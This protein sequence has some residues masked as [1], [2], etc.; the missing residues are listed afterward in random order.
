M[1]DP[2]IAAAVA[3]MGFD[4]TASSMT[5]LSGGVSSDIWRVDLPE[6]SIV[7]KRALARLRVSGDWRAPLERT[8]AEVRWMRVVAGICPGLAPDVLAVDRVDGRIRAFAMPYLAPSGHPLWKHELRDGHADPAFAAQL[9]AAVGAVHAATA[10]RTD[11]RAD[12]DDLAMFAALRLDPY[13]A[14]T[15]AA[16]PDRAQPLDALRAAYIANRH[17]LVHGDVSPKNVLVGPLGPVLLDA[18]CATWGDAAFD[19]AFCCTHLLLKCRWNPAATNAFLA[20]AQSFT[21]AYFTAAS[22]EDVAALE[23]RCAALT[24]GLLLARVDG[25][26]PVEYLDDIARIEVRAVARA[27]LAEPPATI[28]ALVAAWRAALPSVRG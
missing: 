13:L 24:C 23:A 17:V 16:H 25:L 9:G 3:R 26:S 6:M 2:E 27:L 1:A 7:V 19:P 10:D 4:A 14:A 18:E 28:A 21:A 22:W 15:A 12:F 5:E 8:A 11:V 20:C